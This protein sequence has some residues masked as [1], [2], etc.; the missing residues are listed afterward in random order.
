MNYTVLGRVKHNGKLA[1]P[2]S[3]IELDTV[4]GDRLVQAG[5]LAQGADGAHKQPADKKPAEQKPPT[6]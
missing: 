5:Y 1:K 3:K 2:G 6:K 4:D